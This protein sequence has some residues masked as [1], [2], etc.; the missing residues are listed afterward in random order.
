MTDEISNEVT[1]AAR[2]VRATADATKA[3]IGAIEKTGGFL[4]RVFG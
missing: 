3:A 1:E 4:N 2:A